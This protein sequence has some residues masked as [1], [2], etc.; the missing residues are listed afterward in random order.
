MTTR[1]RTRALTL[2]LLG[3]AALSTFIALAL[4]GRAPG[5]WRLRT[6]FFTP[7]E[8]AE[9]TRSEHRRERL[10]A[11]EGEALTPGGVLFIGSST[12]EYFDLTEAFPAANAIN[13]GIGDEDLD[14]LERRLQATV[15]RTR[16]KALVLYAGSVDFRRLARPAEDV[17]SHVERLLERLGSAGRAP[18]VV[19]LGILPEREMSPAMTERLRGTNRALAALAS[20]RPEVSFVD[21]ARPPLVD[22]GTGCLEELYS[23]DAVHLNERGYGVASGWIAEA[24]DRVRVLLHPAR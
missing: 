21:T 22:P 19:L 4:T 5:G 24:D 12:I 23:R 16:C 8:L 2:T 9:R 6:L 17:A 11:F 13:R 7:A 15:E 10:E 1:L 3:V 14:G 20:R 18:Y